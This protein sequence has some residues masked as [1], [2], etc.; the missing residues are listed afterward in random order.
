MTARAA[1]RTRHVMLAVF[2][3]VVLAGLIPSRAARADT[4]LST[5]LDPAVTTRGALVTVTGQ[6][7]PPDALVQLDTLPVV[8]A[9]STSPDGGTLSFWVPSTIETDAGPAPLSLGVH[10]V[11][12]L[13]RGPGKVDAPFA[14]PSTGRLT[15]VGETSDELKLSAVIPDVLFQDSPEGVTLLGEGF[16]PVGEDHALV[17]DGR[18]VRVCW[19]QCDD[20]VRGTVDPSGREIV[21]SGLD[22]AAGVHKVQLRRGS[23][24]A[25]A[26]LTLT[27]AR[28]DAVWI[29][30]GA[31]VIVAALFAVLIVAAWG[32]SRNIT[33]SVGKKPY[34]FLARLFIDPETDT[35]SLGR[36][37]FFLWS[38]VASFGWTY[39]V[40]V[41]AYVQRRFDTPDVP[42]S[43]PGIIAISAGTSVTALGIKNVKGPEGAGS[44]DPGWGDFLTTGGIVAPEKF[45]FLLWTVLGV[46]AF[47]FAV[48]ETDVGHMTA[49]PNIPHNLLYLMGVSSFG[50]LGGKLA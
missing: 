23:M 48:L 21:F 6:S 47:T 41:Q 40:L 45:Q 5:K 44:V 26:A 43:L 3:V 15:I 36:L 16:S 25:R 9:L 20:G 14:L 22:L 4:P 33:Y 12:V 7:L 29:K 13:G 19:S 1:I 32:V 24:L 37:Q 10:A 30:I 31:G 28:C 17:I 34:G 49:L 8:P 18:D 46:A 42:S 27:V 38:A 39:L 35:Y 50:F 11:H 2:S